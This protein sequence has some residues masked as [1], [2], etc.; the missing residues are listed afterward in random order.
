MTQPAISKHL[1]VLER[2][3]LVT[4]RRDAQR[5]PCRLEAA[6]AARGH[7]VARRLPPLLGRAVRAPRRPPRRAPDPRPPP[8]RTRPMTTTDTTDPSPSSRSA[9]ARSASSGRSGAPRQLVFDAHTKPE[10]LRRWLGPARVAVHV[11]RDR[12]APRR[13]P[14]LRDVRARGRGDGDARPLPAMSTRRHASSRR[15]LRRRLDRR[16]DASTRR[17][18]TRSVACTTVTIIVDYASAESRDGALATPM[19]RGM[20]SR[21]TPASPTCWRGAARRRDRPLPPPGRPLRGHGG[22]AVDAGELGRPVAVRRS[23]GTRTSSAT[24]STCTT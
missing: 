19:A 1:K 12:P 14:P 22:R 10:L 18:S 2:A 4:R 20:A 9:I 7:R 24:S 8:G 13:Q 5:R 3:G 23:G 15:S 11:V 21:L 16:R 6:R 17:R